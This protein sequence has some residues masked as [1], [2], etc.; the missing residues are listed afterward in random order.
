M[1]TKWKVFNFKSV[2]KET[3]LEF[4]PLTIFAGAN[5]SGKSTFLQSILLV[6]QTLSHKVSSRSVVLNGALAKLGQFD[7]LRSIDSEADQIVIGWTCRPVHDPRT[8][9]TRPA[10]LRRGPTFYGRPGM[11]LSSI[12]CEIAFDTDESGSK[13]EVTQIQPQLFSSM[14]EVL[15]RDEEGG[16][17]CRIKSRVDAHDTHQATYH[18]ACSQ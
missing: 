12:S 7:D 11:S 17:T 16:D 8:T 18:Y 6:A 3:E 10:A 14:L 2:R 15:S 5:S 9:R 4:A 1:I 13:R